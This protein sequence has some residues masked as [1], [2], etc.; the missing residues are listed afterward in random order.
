M[1]KFNRFAILTL[2]ILI[3]TLISDYAINYFTETIGKTY[4]G[5]WVNMAATVII[6]FPLLSMLDAYVKK[7]SR[8]YIKTSKKITGNSFWGLI[9]GFTLAILV[10]FI[11][12]ANVWYKLDAI[13][14]IKSLI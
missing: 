4:K 7:A 9:L 14:Y 8:T 5:V 12:F 11:L 13:E 3:G 2:T 1:T 6:F 10:L